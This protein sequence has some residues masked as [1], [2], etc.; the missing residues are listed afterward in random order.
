MSYPHEVDE[1][2]ACYAYLEEQVIHAHLGFLGGLACLHF[3]EEVD[4]EIAEEIIVGDLPPRDIWTQ[5][6][7]AA[8][9]LAHWLT[10]CTSDP[11]GVTAACLGLG[12]GLKDNEYLMVRA[13]DPRAPLVFDPRVRRLTNSAEIDNLNKAR[14][15]RVF[16]PVQLGDPRLTIYAIDT[17][18]QTVSWGAALVTKDNSLYVSNTYTIPHFRRR[19]Y[20]AAVLSSMLADAAGKGLKSALLVSSQDGRHLYHSMAFEDRLDCLVFR[21]PAR[22]A[23]GEE[24]Q[25]AFQQNS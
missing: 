4:E 19:G 22:K 7:A 17:E 20:A 15:Y 8:P 3:E 25:A 18:G 9:G 2:I 11:S 14:G 10:Y 6:Q 23:K 13:L 21:Y 5:I 16:A 12:Y 1:F 24:S